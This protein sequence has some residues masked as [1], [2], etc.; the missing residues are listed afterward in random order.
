M[1]INKILFIIITACL[2]FLYIL[3]T[4]AESVNYIESKTINENRKNTK[5]TG[6]IPVVKNL[7]NPV[8]QYKLN[9]S[10]EKVYEDKLNSA[11]VKK[12]KNIK[13]GYET[14]IDS[15]IISI[16][17]YST[18]VMTSTSEVSSFVINKTVNSHISINNVL[19][20]NGLSYTNKVISNK[21]KNDT[22]TKYF[23]FKGITSESAFYVKGGNVYAVFGAGEI[24]PVS[25][26]V[27][28]FE[29]PTKNITNYVINSDSPNNYYV[30]SAYNVKMI[31][32]RSTIENF[33]YS[34]EWNNSN[35]SISIKRGEFV[36]SIT[37]GRNSYYKGKMFPK[38]LEFA[39]E[40]K[41][42]ITYVPISFFEEILGLLFSV[43]S[44]GNVTIS[45][46][47]L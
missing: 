10:I 30:K 34:L 3:P 28:K 22:K 37:V 39:P 9:S 2:I 20:T 15:N 25:K 4:F 8:F 41:N 47:T 46:Y 27:L 33:G 18:N 11:V 1:K 26:G 16:I 19:G 7:S 21:I 6:N 36:T 45:Q 14:V 43:D 12:V 35:G 44:V 40:I 32:L 29:I 13:F 31:P 17:I 23:D 42:G 38:Q 24:A 5:A